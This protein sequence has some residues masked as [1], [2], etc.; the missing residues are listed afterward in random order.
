MLVGGDTA[1]VMDDVEIV[2]QWVPLIMLAVLAASFVLL[3]VAFRSI[4]V[5]LKAVVMNL[6]SVGAAYGMV[7]LF[8]Q[9]DWGSRIF[10]F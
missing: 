6:L 3:L 5:P 1:S 4:I 8:F 2:K 9:E 7:V 10:G